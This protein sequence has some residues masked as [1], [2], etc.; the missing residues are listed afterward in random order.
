[1]RLQGLVTAANEK[2]RM[3]QEEA[4]RMAAAK[5]GKELF[6]ALGHDDEN[7]NALDHITSGPSLD[8]SGLT[9]N[10]GMPLKAGADAGS[11]GSWSGMNYAHTDAGAKVM[12]EAVVYTN[13]G[14][15][16]TQSFVEKYGDNGRRYGGVF[17]DLD[18]CERCRQES[19]Q[20][21]GIPDGGNPD[22]R[23]PAP[24]ILSRAPTMVRWA[25]TVPRTG[26]QRRQ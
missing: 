11:L 23:S 8:S 25:G 18:D 3:E 5:T 26:L 13:R 24:K 20:G 14:A 7:M 10:N 6:M 4:A 2:E 17:P 1:M 16:K 12:N 15:S 21:F 22:S 9:I 19:H